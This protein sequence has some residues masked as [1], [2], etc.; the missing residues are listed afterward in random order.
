MLFLSSLLWS[1][2]LSLFTVCLVLFRFGLSSFV[3]SCFVSFRFVMVRFFSRLCFSLFVS[4]RVGS[5]IILYCLDLSF[6]SFPFLYFQVPLSYFAFFSFPFCPFL[7]FQ[8]P[9]FLLYSLP[10][11]SLPFPSFP[12]L[13]FSSLLVSSL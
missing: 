8:F 6:L 13:S 3:L 5:V 10:F 9:F 7:P 12:F 1:Y 2:F 4:F 11:P